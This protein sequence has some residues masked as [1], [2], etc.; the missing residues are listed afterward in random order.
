MS[1]AR[2]SRGTVIFVKRKQLR[3]EKLLEKTCHYD[4][5]FLRRASIENCSAVERN[6]RFFYKAT[7]IDHSSS[8]ELFV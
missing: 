8:K 5:S 1:N 4:S 6:L 3:C 7:A 2:L